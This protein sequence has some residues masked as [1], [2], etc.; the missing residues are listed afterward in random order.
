MKR[1]NTNNEHATLL[2]KCDVHLKA[3]NNATIAVRWCQ[4]NHSASPVDAAHHSLGHTDIVTA[5][6]GN[7]R[8][9]G[10]CFTKEQGPAHAL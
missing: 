9:A 8:T 1:V 4:R 5:A 10:V 7:S 6:A 3:V 2:E